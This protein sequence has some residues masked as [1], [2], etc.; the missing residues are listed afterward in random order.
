MRTAAAKK[1]LKRAIE[2]ERV[3]PKLLDFD[4]D[5]LGARWTRRLTWTLIISAYRPC[6][7]AI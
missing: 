7:T 3:H 1:Y 4:L 2:I 5:R 6:M